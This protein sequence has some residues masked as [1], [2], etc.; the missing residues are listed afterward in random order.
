MNLTKKI[1]AL[2]LS[3]TFLGQGCSTPSKLSYSEATQTEQ[4]KKR[5]L[6]DVSFTLGLASYHPS[7]RRSEKKN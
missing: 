7:L 5:E 6:K 4:K 3:L 1:A 2:L